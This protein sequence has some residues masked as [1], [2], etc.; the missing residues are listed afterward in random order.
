VGEREHARAVAKTGEVGL[1]MMVG[2]LNQHLRQAPF[3]E[4]R[5]PELVVVHVETLAFESGEVLLRFPGLEQYHGVL[6]GVEGSHGQFADTRQQADG[7][8]L[9]AGDLRKV[10][11]FLA[12]NAGGQRMP[13]ESP[14]VKGRALS[15]GVAVHHRQADY[16]VANPERP[17]GDDRPLQRD[18]RPR[19]PESRGVGKLEQATGNRRV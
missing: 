13:P 4:H 18:D 9:L 17:E 16:Q 15:A 2:G 3:A 12:G 11:E 10:G 1:L 19:P 14:V 8:Q 6:L 5:G 7:E